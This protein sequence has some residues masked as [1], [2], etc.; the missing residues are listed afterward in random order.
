MASETG[1]YLQNQVYAPTAEKSK[2]LFAITC[3]ELEKM[4]EKSKG[5]MTSAQEYMKN[6]KEKMGKEWDE[7]YAPAVKQMYEQ[8]KVA[9]QQTGEALKVQT[10]NLKKNWNEQVEPVLKEK[11]AALNTKP[12]K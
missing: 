6:V 4:G 12:A 8:A 5:S 3:T 1:Q 10:E 2:E 9:G 7:K 11:M